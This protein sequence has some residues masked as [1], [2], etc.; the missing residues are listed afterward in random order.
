M[1]SGILTFLHFLFGAILIAGSPYRIGPGSGQGP[2]R[3]HVHLLVIGA[4]LLSLGVL[5]MLQS[6]RRRR[7]KLAE[8]RSAQ[9]VAAF[10]ETP[11]PSEGGPLHEP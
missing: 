2:L 1:W 10:K 5:Q 7:L 3:W 4:V 6:S 8:A 9:V 11:A